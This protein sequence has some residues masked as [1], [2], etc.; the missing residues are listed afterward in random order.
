MRRS[1]WLLG[2]LG[3]FVLALATTAQAA[4]VFNDVIPFSIDPLNP[5]TTETVSIDGN[6][7]VIVNATLD[8]SGG[9]HLG[10]SVNT[11]DVHG[12]GDPSGI[13]YS[14]HANVNGR[15]NLTSGAQE[16]T[17]IVNLGLQ[18]QGSASNLKIKLTAHITVNA[19]GNVTSVVFDF[20]GLE[21]S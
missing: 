17:L 12:T 6:L 16:A 14:G 15:L 11:N 7:H 2:I 10:I 9:I 5:C 4:N 19:N 1:V 18:S 13:K 8:H 20:T 21:C 3:V